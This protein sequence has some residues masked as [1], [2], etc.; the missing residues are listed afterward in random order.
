MHHRKSLLSQHNDVHP[1]DEKLYKKKPKEKIQLKK[2]RE[3]CKKPCTPFRA[4]SFF[5]ISLVPYR[6]AT[7]TT[8]P[9]RSMAIFYIYKK[10]EKTKNGFFH[11][12]RGKKR[13]E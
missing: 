12:Y 3:K 2:E 10:R 6:C 8:P 4:F 5:F 11:F 13:R 9:F 1:R 7:P